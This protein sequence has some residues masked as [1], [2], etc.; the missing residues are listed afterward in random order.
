MHEQNETEKPHSEYVQRKSLAHKT[1]QNYLNPDFSVTNGHYN[2]RIP[3]KLAPYENEV[4]KL[5][6]QGLTPKYMILFI[7][8]DILAV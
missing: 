7:K 6:S 5:R 8:R 3:G 2:V 1:I 4:T